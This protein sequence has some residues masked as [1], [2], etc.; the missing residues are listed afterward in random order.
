MPGLPVL[1][2][3]VR[4]YHLDRIVQMIGVHYG[5]VLRCTT[6]TCFVLS[7]RYA[8][9]GKLCCCLCLGS[10]SGPI[11]YESWV[12]AEKLI[13]IFSFIKIQI[14]LPK[15][16]WMAVLN[17]VLPQSSGFTRMD[18]PHFP[19]CLLAVNITPRVLAHNCLLW[20]HITFTVHELPCRAILFGTSEPLSICGDNWQ[21]QLWKW[22][23]GR[24]ARLAEGLTTAV[25]WSVSSTRTV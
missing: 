25:S 8:I 3:T 22:L 12:I 17:A 16:L 19:S 23:H 7:S 11:Y 1:Y 20:H 5:I 10:D 9:G 6:V 21:C 24:A 13:N 2:D 14:F 18:S 4:C 15:G